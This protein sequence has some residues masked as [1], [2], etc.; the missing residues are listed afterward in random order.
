MEMLIWLGI[1][2]VMVVTELATQGLTTIWFAGGALIAFLA[3]LFGGGQP[4]QI[5]LFFAV[6]LVLL[7]FTRP[8]AKKHFNT[9]RVK[10]NAES[11]IGESGIV[12]EEIDNLAGTGHVMINGMEWTARASSGNKIEKDAVVSVLEISGV[13]LIVEEK[14]QEE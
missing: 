6:S 12:V 3:A 1:L 14:G 5:V 4:L 7:I 8:V 2:L 10:T 13:K 9:D 11:L